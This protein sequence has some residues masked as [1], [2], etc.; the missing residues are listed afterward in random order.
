MEHV[1]G[2]AGPDSLSAR[3]AGGRLPLGEAIT[4]LDE[5]TRIVGEGHRQGRTDGEL[6][7]ARV[8]VDG[9]RVRVS[10]PA[11]ASEIAF[12]SPQQL[13]GKAADPRADVFALG[14]IAYRAVV[15]VDPF[16]DTASD[17]ASRLAA[18]EKGPA[19]PLQYMPKLAD[20]LRQA[21]LIALARNLT[22][23]FADALTMRAAL[24]GE[25]QVALDT[26]TLRWAVAEG[27]PEGEVTDGMA[28]FLADGAEITATGAPGEPGLA[29]GGL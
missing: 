12:Q 21:L 5:L 6:I 14:V 4:L 22:E 15:G 28:E 20:H 10:A 11:G 9:P 19:D 26:P 25:S 7:P 17:P 8:L 1:A 13:E 3:L 16:G 29:G 18:I 23:R 27:A 24:R 2:S